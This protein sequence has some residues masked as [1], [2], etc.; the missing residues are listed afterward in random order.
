[1]GN[2]VHVLYTDAPDRPSGCGRVTF[3]RYSVKLGVL[4]LCSYSLMG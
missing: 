4:N 1:M 3:T 2:I